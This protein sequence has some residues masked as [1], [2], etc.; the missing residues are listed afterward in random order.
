MLRHMSFLPHLVLELGY[1]ALSLRCSP[2]LRSDRNAVL[3]RR[4]V[5][6]CITLIGPE[7]TTEINQSWHPFYNPHSRNVQGSSI[8]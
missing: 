8:F 4:L 5:N 6:S 3:G 1:P 2:L 7:T